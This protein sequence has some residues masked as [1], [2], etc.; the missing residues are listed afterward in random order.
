MKSGSTNN[1]ALKLSAL[2][3]SCLFFS[4]PMRS[5]TAQTVQNAAPARQIVFNHDIRPILADKC[6]GCHG[7]DA[8]AKKIKLRLDSEGA[9]TADLGRGRRAIVPGNPEQSQLVRRITSGDELMRMPP[10]DSGRKLTQ[11]EISL[12]VEWVRQG[13]R[14]QRHWSFMTPIRPVLPKIKNKEWP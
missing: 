10:V 13:A 1:L 12:L 4:Q 3:L 2:L 7:P 8:P 11:A 14:W 9:A 6:L 5:V